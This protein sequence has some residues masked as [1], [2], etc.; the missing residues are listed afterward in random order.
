[1]RVARLLAG[2]LV[3]GLPLSL[4]AA[5]AHGA[6]DGLIVWA[7]EAQAAVIRDQLAEGFRG[8]PVTVVT[9]EVGD[10][11]A[12]LRTVD[13]AI[14]PDVIWGDAAS[15]GALVADRTVRRLPLSAA[16]RAQFP[17]NLLDAFRYGF[18]DY[19]VPVTVENV[20]LVVNLDLVPQVP[21][22][23]RELERSSRRLLASNRA[24]VGLAVG[25]GEPGAEALLGPLF[26][27][28]G[29]YLF[30][31]NASGGLDPYNL[32][33]SSAALQSNAE[34]IDQW[35]DDGLVVA[36]LSVAQA[37]RAFVSGRAP[38]WI[39]GPDSR[40]VLE[41]L[42][43]P[44]AIGSIP[45]I[46]DGREALPFLEVQGAM[47]TVFADRR[48]TGDLATALVRRYFAQSAAQA[49][50]AAATRTAP[51]LREAR[52]SR[53]VAD[54]ARAGAGG[55]PL[56]NIV[57]ADAVWGP[58]RVAWAQATAGASAV[59]AATTFARAQQSVVR[60]IG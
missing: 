45:P 40:P 56:P 7:P 5:P 37:Q 16:L 12:G 51:A 43:F 60:A 15:T 33:L 58:F 8:A 39:T 18:A 59:P 10:V 25:Q 49:A 21:E 30:G 54:F 4:L 52:V 32:G 38:F 55:V 44:V 34:R 28:L 27:G 42:A 2:A 20:A 11:A 29:G 23:F 1:M 17:P 47:V 36:D 14:A 24:S 3:A 53:A 31:K 57:Q 26:T 19:G 35:N 48:G 9:T 22:T 13:A 46:V 41:A 50:L 6:T